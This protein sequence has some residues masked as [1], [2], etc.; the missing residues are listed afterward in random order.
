MLLDDAAHMSSAVPYWH[1]PVLSQ[2]PG[3]L[4]TSHPPAPDEE[5]WPPL[6]VPP[7]AVQ[8]WQAAPEAPHCVSLTR[9]THRLPWQQP[10]GHV[11]ALQVEPASAPA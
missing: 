9:L 8:S 1:V 10:C 2:Q 11:D 4:L 6:H 5:H 7:V 3:Q